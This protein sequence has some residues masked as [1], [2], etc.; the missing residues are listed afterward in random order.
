MNVRGSVH[1]RQVF[2]VEPIFEIDQSQTTKSHAFNTLLKLTCHNFHK[3]SMAKY[4]PWLKF[5]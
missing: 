3:D 1:L 2:C 4:I 5:Y